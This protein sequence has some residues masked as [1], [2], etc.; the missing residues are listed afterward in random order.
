M[1]GETRNGCVFAGQWE[2]RGAVIELGAEPIGSRMAQLAILREPGRHVIWRCRRPILLYMA[3]GARSG[4][5]R[6]LPAGMT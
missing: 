1:A 3:T 6:V 5:G 4:Q 2:F